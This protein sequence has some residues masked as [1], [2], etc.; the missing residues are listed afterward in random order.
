[1]VFKELAHSLGGATPQV[2]PQ[3][4]AAKKPAW[5]TTTSA[6]GFEIIPGLLDLYWSAV[7]AGKTQ[8]HSRRALKVRELIPEDFRG[9]RGKARARTYGRMLRIVDYVSG[10]TD[11]YALSVYRKLNGIALPT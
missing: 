1:M 7:L 8:A 6:L 10:M 5:S 3:A 9:P 2:T 11:S 4:G